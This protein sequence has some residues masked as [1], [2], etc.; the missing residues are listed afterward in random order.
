MTTSVAD[1]VQPRP[2]L[3]LDVDDL[4]TLARS[5]TH[6]RIRKSSDLLPFP[7][8]TTEKL[9][10]PCRIWEEPQT[11]IPLDSVHRDPPNMIAG[12][13]I[14]RRSTVSCEKFSLQSE[15]PLGTA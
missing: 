8:K 1:R 13:V 12:A 15:I 2:Q 4:R 6:R 5:G 9:A 10:S 11:W 7:V 3:G 14:M